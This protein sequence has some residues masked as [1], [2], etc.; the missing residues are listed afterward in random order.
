MI[1]GFQSSFV[2]ERGI[3]VDTWKLASTLQYLSEIFDGV[4]DVPIGFQ[5]DFASIPRFFH[6]LLP[7]NGDY[8]APAVVHDFMYQT[9]ICN[10]MTA[11]LIFLE[12]MQSV[13]VS[14]WKRWSMYQ[15]VN[16]F[17]GEAWD[18]HRKN[19]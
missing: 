8:D 13:G 19:S 2:L 4:I 6:R 17:G 9:A 12:A 18:K 10:K 11:D 15:A 7:K 5:T 3:G 14:R 1:S 16:W